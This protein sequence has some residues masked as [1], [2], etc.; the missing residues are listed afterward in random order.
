[1][2]FAFALFKYFPFGGLQSDMLR[3]AECAAARGHEVTVFTGA[4]EGPGPV[5]EFACGCW[6]AAAARIIVAP[7]NSRCASPGR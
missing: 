7:G 2:R 4:W 6:S 3:I 5:P 1:M